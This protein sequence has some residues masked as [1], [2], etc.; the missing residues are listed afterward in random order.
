MF[1][2]NLFLSY[3]I[4]NFFRNH[5]YISFLLVTSFKIISASSFGEDDAHESDMEL[6]RYLVE[7]AALHKLLQAEHCLLLQIIPAPWQSNVFQMI[8][9]KAVEV[10]VSDG[11]VNDLRLLE[12]IIFNVMIKNNNNTFVSSAIKFGLIYFLICNV[13]VCV[14]LNL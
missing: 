14:F 8:A 2:Y 7:V 5:Y 9:K 1:L 3:H 13:Q 12:I 6:E 4:V 10:I 11:E